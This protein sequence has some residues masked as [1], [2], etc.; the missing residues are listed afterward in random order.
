MRPYKSQ[1]SVFKDL[2]GAFLQEEVEGETKAWMEEHKKECMHCR[3][4][5]Q[6]YDRSGGHDENEENI[7]ENTFDKDKEAVRRGRLILSAGLG[8]VIFVAIWASIWLG[9]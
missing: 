7:K 6:E 2:Y 3:E 5:C 8:L 1:C 4:W 9:L